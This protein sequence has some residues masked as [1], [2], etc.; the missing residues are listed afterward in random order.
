[1]TL[2]LALTPPLT[3]PLAL[4]LTLSPMPNFVPSQPG[5][6]ALGKEKFD[7]VVFDTAPTGHTLR[8]LAFPDFLEKLL[9]KVGAPTSHTLFSSHT[10]HLTPLISNLSSHTSPSHVSPPGH[11]PQIVALRSR[12]GGA[13]ALLGGLL[14]GADPVAKVATRSWAQIRRTSCGSAS[15]TARVAH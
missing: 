2:S 4:P 13:I 8:L 12:V 5:N 9:S 15:A 14:G 10:S 3:L 11:P 1:M 7:R 6:E